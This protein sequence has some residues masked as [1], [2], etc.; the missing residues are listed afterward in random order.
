MRIVS[1]I[2]AGALVTCSCISLPYVPIDP[3]GTWIATDIPNGPSQSLLTCSPEGRFSLE[4][5]YPG[6]TDQTNY[7]CTAS[8]IWTVAGRTCTLVVRSSNYPEVLKAGARFSI[9]SV[10]R[11]NLII[12]VVDVPDLTI[13]RRSKK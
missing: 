2:F 12:G 13:Y 6:A 1:I 5:L 7:T 9:V 10:S 8:G 11:D 4:E 3:T